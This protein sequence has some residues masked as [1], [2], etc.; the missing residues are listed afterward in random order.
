M[1]IAIVGLDDDFVIEFSNQLASALNLQHVNFNSE[2][3]KILLTSINQSLFETND[4]M[5]EKETILLKNLIDLDNVIISI[6]DDAFLSN[7]NYKLLNN[8][9]TILIEKKENDKILNNIQKL[10]KKHC[11]LIINQENIEINSILNKI[12]GNYN[13]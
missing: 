2:Y 6:N 3:D 9:L 7:V 8:I 4:I 1:K 13:G 10:I 12:R 5:E 11:K